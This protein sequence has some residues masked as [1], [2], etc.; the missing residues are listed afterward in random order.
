MFAKRFLR[1]LTLPLASAGTLNWALFESNKPPKSKFVGFFKPEGTTNYESDHTFPITAHPVHP[2]FEQS[3]AD[4]A[5]KSTQ[6]FQL[7]EFAP[8]DLMITVA[9]LRLLGIERASLRDIGRERGGMNCFVSHLLLVEDA[10]PVVIQS[11]ED[12]FNSIDEFRSDSLN[13]L[14]PLFQKVLCTIAHIKPSTIDNA[15][16]I[17][18]TNALEVF[19]LGNGTII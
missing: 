16:I 17:L 10:R 8:R 1:R 6:S 15:N 9:F 11:A 2:V 4:W 12:L 7:L 18:H 19:Y 5:E 13:H 3:L 14:R